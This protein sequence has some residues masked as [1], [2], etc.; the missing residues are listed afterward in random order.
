VG[1]HT[2]CSFVKDEALYQISRIVPSKPLG[3]DISISL[4]DSQQDSTPT[5][6]NITVG[7]GGVVH[8]G[9]AI[10]NFEITGVAPEPS[11]DTYNVLEPA[12]YGNDYVLA[13][14]SKIHGRRLEMRLWMN[15]QP[16]R[17]TP[18]DRGS[19]KRRLLRPSSKNST[20]HHDEIVDIF[21]LQP[22]TM[23]EDLE[24]AITAVAEYR[25]VWDENPMV[26][27]QQTQIS[28][29]EVR[30]YLGVT[31]TSISAPYRFWSTVM[32]HSPGPDCFELNAVGRSIEQVLCISSVP[33]SMKLIRPSQQSS[34]TQNLESAEP[35]ISVES[36]S[37][38]Q[39]DG[40]AI[41]PQ[42]ALDSSSAAENPY[43][44]DTSQNTCDSSGDMGTALIQNIISSH[45][46]DLSSTLWVI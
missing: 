44:E 30:D 1:T 40:P 22:T 3:S 23:G 29:R 35:S 6:L 24:N 31:E 27:E 46:V 7:I 42:S 2:L 10:T 20:Q 15:G 39:R 4:S 34:P 28:S 12:E 26:L 38:G 32:G 37:A 18:R 14:T 45:V 25:F 8:V 43:T 16:I 21:A 36:D 33:V 17:L 9:S 19:A 5:G 13:F 41:A 11:Y